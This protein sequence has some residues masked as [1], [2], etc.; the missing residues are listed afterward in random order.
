MKI[1][2]FSS[3]RE[4]NIAWNFTNWSRLFYRILIY[5]RRA[6]NKNNTENKKNTELSLGTHTTVVFCWYRSKYYFVREKWALCSIWKTM[7]RT[8]TLFSIHYTRAPYTTLH[9]KCTSLVSASRPLLLFFF[10]EFFLRV[11]VYY[12]LQK[13]PRLSLFVCIP[14]ESLFK[15]SAEQREQKTIHKNNDGKKASS[16]SGQKMR[17]AR[18]RRQKLN[19]E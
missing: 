5:I 13:A 17:S 18:L 8:I 9:I 19:L 10:C 6:L 11:Y 7:H 4:I 15:F 3:E 12:S 14:V 16:E 2:T 1:T